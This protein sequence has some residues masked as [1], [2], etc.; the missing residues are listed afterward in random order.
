MSLESVMGAIFGVTFLSEAMS[1]QEIIGATLM[2]GAVI[3]TQ[4]KIKRLD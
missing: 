4:I 2:F 1:R 3:L